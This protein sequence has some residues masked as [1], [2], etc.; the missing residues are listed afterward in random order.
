MLGID[1]FPHCFLNN[2]LLLLLELLLALTSLFFPRF[3][4][5]SVV[6]L[7]LHALLFFLDL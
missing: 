7:H 6:F 3:H 5:F 2:L 1:L 4:H